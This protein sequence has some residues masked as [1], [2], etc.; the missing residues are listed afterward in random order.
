MIFDVYRGY[1][2]NGIPIEISIVDTNL[3]KQFALRV[4]SEALGYSEDALL[5]LNRDIK[6]DT[7]A[8][9]AELIVAVSAKDMYLIV[10]H[11]I[12]VEMQSH[13]PQWLVD[14]LKLLP[15]GRKPI[16]Y[17]VSP[18]LAPMELFSSHA[19]TVGVAR[20]PWL[21]LEQSEQF[22]ERLVASFVPEGLP[23][24]NESQ[25]AAINKIASGNP[26]LLVDIVRLAATSSAATFINTVADNQSTR[27]SESLSQLIAWHLTQ[28]S[29]DGLER[30]L[31]RLLSMVSPIT[32]VAPE[33]RTP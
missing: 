29:A 8:G 5:E 23:S 16:I 32:E 21:N 26:K 3:A 19:Q 7:P 14:T 24:W 33:K 15:I 18:L 30:K 4:A 22:L 27:F 1:A 31:L 11:D 9:L 10:F 6:Y 17:C 25:H 2:Q 28:F 13:V 20:I 12:A